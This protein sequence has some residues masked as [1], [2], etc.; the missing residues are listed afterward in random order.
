MAD[1]LNFLAWSQPFCLCCAFCK[2]IPHEYF[3]IFILISFDW[4]FLHFYQHHN[5]CLVKI[6]SIYSLSPF[7]ILFSFRRGGEDI[8]FRANALELIIFMLCSLFFS[9]SNYYFITFQ[10]CL[11]VRSR[12]GMGQGFWKGNHFYIFISL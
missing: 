6:I 9:K 11:C 10:L 5:S 4:I 3:R 8:K 1:I 7:Y 2:F 12:R